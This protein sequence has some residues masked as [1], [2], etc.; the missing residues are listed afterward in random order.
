MA[1]KIPPKDRERLLSMSHGWLACM[2]AKVAKE[3]EDEGTARDLMRDIQGARKK[4]GLKSSDLVEVE[5]VA[6][7]EAWEEEIKKKVNASKLSKGV[8]LKVIVL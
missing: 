2:K 4:L 3:L 5:L 6:W 1:E 8:E 7:P